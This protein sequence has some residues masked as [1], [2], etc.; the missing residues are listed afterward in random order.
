M[1]KI[2]RWLLAIAIYIVIIAILVYTK[3]A[4]MF[5]SER[6]VKT[7]GLGNNETESMFSPMIV[8]PI[9]A[10]LAYYVGALVESI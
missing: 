9:I 6:K 8:F 10:I 1:I 2:N 4:M 5:D 3:P 7:W